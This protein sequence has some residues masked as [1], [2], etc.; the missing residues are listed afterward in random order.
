VNEATFKLY[1][2]VGRGAAG[3]CRGLATE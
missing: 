1:V 2:K 3:V